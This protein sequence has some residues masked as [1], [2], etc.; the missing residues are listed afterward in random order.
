MLDILNEI[1][2]PVLKW[3]YERAIINENVFKVCHTSLMQLYNE[4]AQSIDIEE[5]ILQGAKFFMYWLPSIPVDILQA[6]FITHRQKIIGEEYPKNP[7]TYIRDINTYI[8]QKL[9]TIITTERGYRRQF[10][11]NLDISRDL[12]HLHEV[13][14]QKRAKQYLREICTS[15]ISFWKYGNGGCDEM[16][17][18]LTCLNEWKIFALNE[19]DTCFVFDEQ[20]AS[21]YELHR[22]FIKNQNDISSIVQ[23]MK[24]IIVNI[25]IYRSIE[26]MKFWYFW[27]SQLSTLD[28]DLYGLTNDNVYEYSDILAKIFNDWG[29]FLSQMDLKFLGCGNCSVVVPPIKLTVD[30]NIPPREV[31]SMAHKFVTILQRLKDDKDALS[32]NKLGENVLDLVRVIVNNVEIEKIGKMFNEQYARLIHA[33]ML[34]KW[35]DNVNNNNSNNIDWEDFFKDFSTYARDIIYCL[36]TTFPSNDFWVFLIHYLRDGEKTLEQLYCDVDMLSNHVQYYITL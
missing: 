18:V 5:L 17:K 23:I 20:C 10:V 30:N 27:L 22:Y 26:S 25:T 21:S 36:D 6:L 2:F 13:H 15:L 3:F 16:T 8:Q 19:P 14:Q 31:I 24:K 29:R 1:A 11:Q 35:K 7:H 34:N 32:K 4:D 9:K 28:D 33:K 12:A